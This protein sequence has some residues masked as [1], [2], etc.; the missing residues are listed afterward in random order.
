MQQKIISFHYKN[1]KQMNK[2]IFS[3][4]IFFK[5]NRLKPRKYRNI[6]NTEKFKQFA[7]DTGAIYVNW[8]DQKTKNF[9][10]REWLINFN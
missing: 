6:T 8:Y 5:G 9:E 10:K 4:T 1:N 3:A 2:K 7:T